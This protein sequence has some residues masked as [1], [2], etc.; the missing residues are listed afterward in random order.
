ML[1]YR[2]VKN[3]GHPQFPLQSGRRFT[4]PIIKVP[5]HDD[6][7]SW[8]SPFR[9]EVTEPL[10]LP[11]SSTGRESKMQTETV[12]NRSCLEGAMEDPPLFKSMGGNIDVEPVPHGN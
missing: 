10:D 1:T 2:G 11:I 5:G 3:L 4:I 7:V 12:Q 6:R 8:T 9:N